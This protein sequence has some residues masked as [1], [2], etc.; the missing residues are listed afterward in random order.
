MK[1]PINFKMFN[2]LSS[3]FTNFSTSALQHSR[4]SPPFTLVEILMAI[5][6]MALLMTAAMPAFT[7]MMKGQGV[8]A[9]ARNLGQILKLARSHAINNREY[10]AVLIP[11][12]PGT[13][14]DIPTNYRNRSFRVCLVTKDSSGNYKFKRWLPGESWQFMSTGVACIDIDDNINYDNGNFANAS[15]IQGVNCDD[16]GG[17]T[18]TDLTGIIFKPTG[19]T[20]GTAYIVVGEAAE[21]GG[22]LIRTNPSGDVNIS[23]NQYTGRVTFED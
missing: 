23:I 1:K 4:T 22:G 5:V 13:P 6:I 3:K 14:T 8:S 15:I 21:S 16:I 12:T 10:V 2:F 7:E 18:D 11:K 19:Q 9:S 20:L 17:S